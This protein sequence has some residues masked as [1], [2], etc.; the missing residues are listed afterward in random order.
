MKGKPITV[1][2]VDPLI[3]SAPHPR[4]FSIRTLACCFVRVSDLNALE[5]RKWNQRLELAQ[6]FSIV[7]YVLERNE[8]ADCFRQ[9]ADDTL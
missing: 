6:R 2:G 9:E 1:W 7:F 8:R 5:Q 3:L 4:T